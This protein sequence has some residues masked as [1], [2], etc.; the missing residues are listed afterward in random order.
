MLMLRILTLPIAMA[1]FA[2]LY[3]AATKAPAAVEVTSLLIWPT[4]ALL[5]IGQGIRKAFC[6]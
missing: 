1:A 3:V 4:L 2:T 5:L 6:N